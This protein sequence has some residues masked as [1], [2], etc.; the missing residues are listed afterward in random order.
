MPPCGQIGWMSEISCA[1]S[2]VWAATSDLTQATSGLRGVLSIF[3]QTPSCEFVPPCGQIE[4]MSEICCATRDVWAATSDLRRVASDLGRVMSDLR[5]VMSDLRQV[6]SDL[7]RSLCSRCSQTHR[8]KRRPNPQDDL[9]CGGGAAAAGS[10]GIDHQRVE[11]GLQA[12]E[13]HLNRCVA[14][15]GNPAT[16]LDRHRQI[17]PNVSVRFIVNTDLAPRTKHQGPSTAPP[18]TSTRRT[19]PHARPAPCARQ[20]PSTTRVPTRGSRSARRS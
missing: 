16:R 14:F 10:S 3:Q 7:S 11:A 20:S 18:P 17:L 13:R 12:R 8:V 15:L 4:W 5:S 2:G 6:M 19:A 1:T 9:T